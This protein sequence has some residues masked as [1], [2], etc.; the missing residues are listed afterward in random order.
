MHEILKIYQARQIECVPD[1][2]GVKW[3][4]FFVGTE[5][6]WYTNESLLYMHGERLTICKFFFLKKGTKLQS[7]IQFSL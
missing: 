7:K 3:L 6:L 5:G 2:R 1:L 4:T